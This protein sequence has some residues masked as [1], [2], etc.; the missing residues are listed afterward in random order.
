MLPSRVY[1]ILEP[2][3]HEV[4]LCIM[5]RTSSDIAKRRVRKFFSEYNGITLRIKGGDLIKQGLKPGPRY[6]AI[7][8]GVLCEKIDGKLKSKKEELA[9]MRELIGNERKNK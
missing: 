5:A 6:K 9:C 7:L 8:R 3:A 2:L 4:T 1:D